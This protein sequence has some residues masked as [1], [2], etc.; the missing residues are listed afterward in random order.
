MFLGYW[1]IRKAMWARA[2]IIQSNA[3]SLKKF[4]EFMLNRGEVFPE[5]VTAM[6]QRIKE[7]L[8][9]WMATLKRYNDPAVDVENVWQ[10]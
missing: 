10:V 7:D 4:Y 2:A 9:E 3:R 5:A 6:K 8:P 1:F